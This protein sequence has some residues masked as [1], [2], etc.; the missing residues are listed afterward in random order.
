M[1]DIVPIAYGGADYSKMSPPNSVI[2]VSKFSSVEELAKYI[3]TLDEN[4]ENYLS[5]F[6]W[7]R[8]YVVKRDNMPIL[9]NLCKKLNEPVVHKSY[10]NL[11][12]WWKNE[13]CKFGNKLPKI[14]FT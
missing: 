8:N 12:E 1:R 10:T 3:K 6:E 13:M 11:M 7:K 5:Y 14:L 2:D 9:C 4:P